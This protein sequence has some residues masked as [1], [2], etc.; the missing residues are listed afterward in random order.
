MHLLGVADDAIDLRHVG[1]AAGL[2]LRGA[3][4][5]DEARMRPLAL[6][7]TDGLAGLAHRLGGDGAGVDDDGVLEPGGG[8]MA[9]HDLR[10]E[11]VEPA[12]QRDDADRRCRIVATCHPGNRA[13][14]NSA[15]GFDVNSRAVIRD[16][17]LAQSVSNLRLLGPGS[18]RY[19][20]RPG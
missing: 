10:L 4:G 3:A 12:A 17:G 1:E 15:F 6:E 11:S 18:P 16:P 20:L 2:D 14:R 19:A 13:G 7:P 8:G 5:D 9:P